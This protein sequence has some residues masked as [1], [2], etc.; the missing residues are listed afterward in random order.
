[1]KQWAFILCLLVS[2]L[3][4]RT[5]AEEG[6]PTRRVQYLLRLMTAVRSLPKAERKALHDESAAVFA[7]TC[8]SSDPTLALSCAFESAERICAKSSRRDAC[9]IMLDASI[10]EQL[11]T[12]RFISSRE[13]YEMMSR[14]SDYKERMADSLDHRYGSIVV[15]FSLSK[16]A[17]CK[18]SDLACFAKAVDSYCQAE[19]RQGRLSYQSCAALI[20][21][22]IGNHS[23]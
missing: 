9:L 3:S 11:N 20:A 23:P 17:A 10:V 12:K 14:G 7:G 8:K 16:D 4:L 15:A 1:M 5:D 19:A 6:P 22:F 18:A 13:R 21:L 2:G